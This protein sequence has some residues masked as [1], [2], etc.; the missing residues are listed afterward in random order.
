MY[1]DSNQSFNCLPAVFAWGNLHTASSG[2]STHTSSFILQQSSSYELELFSF[3]Y[4]SCLS[5][6]WDLPNR[7]LT[8]SPQHMREYLLKLA[9]ASQCNIFVCRK[10]C[11]LHPVI[12]ESQQAA[13]TLGSMLT[14]SKFQNML[15]PIRSLSEQP[16][17]GFSPLYIVQCMYTTR[18][19]ISISLI[20]CTRFNV[21][22]NIT[23]L[24]LV[25]NWQCTHQV[26][27]FPDTF[28]L[29]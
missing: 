22:A 23:W 15:R 4:A 27:L 9:S 3:L 13:P 28:N 18:R 19:C 24:I 25:A 21:R 12:L 8:Y 14:F 2:R 11:M 6:M 5:S 17:A 20:E 16:A 7:F 26:T 10:C 1:N 29:L